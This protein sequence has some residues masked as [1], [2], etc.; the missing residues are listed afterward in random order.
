MDAK[1]A[2][3]ELNETLLS[4]GVNEEIRPYGVKGKLTD[5]LIKLLMPDQTFEGVVP[6]ILIDDEFDLKAFGIKGRAIFTPGH[7]L[8]SISVIL[9]SGE[10]IVGDL[11]NGAPFKG[12]LFASNTS[13]SKKSFERIMSFGPKKIYVS[14]GGPFEPEAIKRML[15]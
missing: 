10:A 2:I 12:P 6:D 13:R 4:R 7:T 9:D 5:I 11:V 3:H 15:K 14:H 1:V 8:G